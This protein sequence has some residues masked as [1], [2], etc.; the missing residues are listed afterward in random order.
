MRPAL[1]GG[2]IPLLVRIL[3]VCDV[4]DSLASDRPYRGTR[5]WDDAIL[6]IRRNA[7]TQFDPRIVTAFADCEPAMREIYQALAA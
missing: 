7:G 3:S 4:Y 5:S 6:E 1:S 2:A